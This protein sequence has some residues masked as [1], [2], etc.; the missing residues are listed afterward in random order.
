MI[1]LTMI[2]RARAI[3]YSKIQ[4]DVIY[5]SR[6]KEIFAVLKLTKQ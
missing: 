1:S 4:E 5:K 3:I 6:A 2:I